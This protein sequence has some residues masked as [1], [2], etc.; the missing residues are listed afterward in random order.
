MAKIVSFGAYRARLRG[1]SYWARR[2]EFHRWFWGQSLDRLAS[3]I[4][5][6]TKERTMSDKKDLKI[7]APAGEKHM[8]LTRTFNA[9]RSLVWRAVS[10]PEHVIRWFGPHSHANKV[11]RFD[12]RVG[13]GWRIQSS[14]ADGMVIV[15]HGEYRE[16]EPEWKTVQTFAVEGMYDDQY[17]VETMTLEEVDGRTVYKVVSEMPDVASRD[18][19]LASGM[20]VGVVEGFERLDAILEE[21]K[22]GDR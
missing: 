10:Q 22:A 13:G 8:V 21:L 14:M 4:E 9:P 2:L 17:A 16:I 6:L 18:G 20:E 12:W 5:T 1:R 7:E 11:L 19:M 3:Y 15:F